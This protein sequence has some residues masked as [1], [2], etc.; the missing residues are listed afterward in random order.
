M[1]SNNK[2]FVYRV[3]LGQLLIIDEAADF[4]KFC[5]CINDDDIIDTLL[6]ERTPLSI[7][8][9]YI[10]LQG[11]CAPQNPKHTHH[12]HTLNRK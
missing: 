9:C 6:R 8:P 10:Y 12:H 2:W 7:S 11:F 3:I 1:S 5:K 4:Q